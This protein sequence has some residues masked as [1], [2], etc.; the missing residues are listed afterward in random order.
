MSTEVILLS[1]IPG[2]GAEGDRVRVADGFARNYLFPRRLASLPEAASARH[3]ETLRK[4]R[5]ARE[6][7]ERA[8]AEELARRLKALVCTIPMPSAQE[9]KIFGGVTA[10][11]IVETLAKQ[12][13][14]LDRKQI[15]MDR[16]L[17]SPGEFS[18]TVHPHPD[19]AATLK[20]VITATD[21]AVAATKSSR[22]SGKKVH[23]A[24]R[25]QRPVAHASASVAEKPTDQKPAKK[26]HKT[27]KKSS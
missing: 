3:L 7:T 20:V 27:V 24:E 14:V 16:P 2:V 6:A 19:V 17:H 18:V 21:V 11:Q 1:N 22:P 15:K 13:L 4:I 26:I 25:E 8:G 12:G 9:G 10:A 23:R 5:T